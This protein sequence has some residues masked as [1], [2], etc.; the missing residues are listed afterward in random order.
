[1][2]NRYIYN[3]SHIDLDGIASAKIIEEVFG[4]DKVDCYLTNYPFNERQLEK[5]KKDVDRLKEQSNEKYAGV[6]ITDLSFKTDD[7]DFILKLKDIFG[8]VPITYIDHHESTDMNHKDLFSD[9]YVDKSGSYAGSGLTFQLFKQYIK[10][11]PDTMKQIEEFNKIADHYDLWKLDSYW[12]KGLALT[13][14]AELF[15][16]YD[17]KNWSYRTLSDLNNDYLLRQL[18]KSV[19]RSKD[20]LVSKLEESKTLSTFEFEG[21][22]YTVAFVYA[23]QYRNY[24]A[25]KMKEDV[26]LIANP[27]TFSVSF[28]SK[29]LPV[30]K[31]C[32]IYKGG[33]HELA[34]A[35]RMEK[36]KF[37]NA[38]LILN[39]YK[40][41]L[42]KGDINA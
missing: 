12:E 41:F 20:F 13:D 6:F 5:I 22:E 28:R 4:K 3:I 31:Y 34:G 26:I 33:G 38:E 7:R 8:D 29:S 39:E 40:N 21:K 14:I 18:S 24:I 2:D 36:S 1:M 27:T 11:S 17:V 9:F 32:E 15:S 23:S 30:H 35:C 16:P 37:F 10:A 19:Q 42:L 25:H